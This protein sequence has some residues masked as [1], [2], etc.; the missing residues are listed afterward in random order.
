[1][2]KAKMIEDMCS[3]LSK[4]ERK[5]MGQRC[6]DCK[7]FDSKDYCFYELTA[8]KLYNANCRI[9]GDDEIIVKKSEYEELKGIA[10]AYDDLP[11][12]E[13]DWGV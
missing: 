6:V 7:F 5:C 1:M 2:K 10:K 4:S 13:P 3:I 12:I 11:Y 8:I 9:I